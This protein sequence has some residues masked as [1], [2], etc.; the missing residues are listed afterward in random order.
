MPRVYL[1]EEDS[2]NAFATGRSSRHATVA[3]TRALVKLMRHEEKGVL[4]HELSH[5]KNRDVLIG[6]VAALLARAIILMARMGHYESLFGGSGRDERD[7]AG[8]LSE[9]FRL[10]LAPTAAIVVRLAVSRSREYMADASGAEMTGDPCGLARALEKLNRHSS[11][12]PLLVPAATAH[13][14][15]VQPLVLDG[16]TNLFST[17]P[18]VPKHLE[19]LIRQPVLW[20]ARIL[21][22]C[23]PAAV[24][25]S[26][27]DRRDVSD[28]CQN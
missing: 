9:L 16:L 17:R 4:A 7:R 19:R 18:P 11:R 2:P 6:T 14:F 22:T 25:N 23:A 28:D 5:I 21:K 26:P 13:L 12:Q 24:R 15:I 10:V 1:I 8:P 20:G 3:V 27:P